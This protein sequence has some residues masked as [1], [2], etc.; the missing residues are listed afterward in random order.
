MTTGTFAA[1][2]KPKQGEKFEIKTKARVWKSW[3]LFCLEGAC[4]ANPG[5]TGAVT[6]L[7]LINICSVTK[8]DEIVSVTTI[9]YPQWKHEKK[10]VV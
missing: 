10:G 4:M 2:D 8:A 1:V 3:T 9:S 5:V 6:S 7:T